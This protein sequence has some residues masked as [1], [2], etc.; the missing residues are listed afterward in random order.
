MCLYRQ[1]ISWNQKKILFSQNF[2]SVGDTKHTM[3]GVLD[4]SKYTVVGVLQVYLVVPGGT[5]ILS[6][7]AV[8][9]K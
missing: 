3:V 6:P 8:F 5:E 4:T 9:Q 2:E 1:V 7:V